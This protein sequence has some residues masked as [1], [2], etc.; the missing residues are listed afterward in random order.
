MRASQVVEIG[1][2]TCRN[3][4]GGYS[5][6][7]VTGWNLV[8]EIPACSV[9]MSESMSTGIQSTLL[10]EGILDGK[11]LRYADVEMIWSSQHDFSIGKY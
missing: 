7:V 5:F 3:E 8:E 2:T 9:M 10:K 1:F 6:N 4:I 11:T